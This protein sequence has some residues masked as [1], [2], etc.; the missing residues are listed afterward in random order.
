VIGVIFATMAEAGP[1]LALG[2]AVQFDNEALRLFKVPALPR[3]LVTISGMGK[4]AAA[5]ACHAQ[6]R[7][8]KVDEVV[9][10]GA[11]GALQPEP[12]YAPGSVFCVATAV[13]GDHEVP[14]E[15]PRP[16]ISDGKID[17]DL[18]AARLITCD[19]PVFDEETRRALS[20]KADLVDMEGAA[21]ARVAAM[22]QTPWTM[23]KGVTDGAG[24]LDRAALYANLAGVSETIGTLLWERFKTL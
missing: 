8:F 18:R 5:V 3:I 20:A 23:V 17:W 21:I 6:I 2:H 1:F 11:C 12:G 16:I 9:N 24:P 19:R 13:E 14:G 7:E 22:Y 15:E 4:V 10:A